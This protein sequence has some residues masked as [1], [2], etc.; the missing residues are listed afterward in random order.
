VVSRPALEAAL[1]SG[2]LAGVGLDVYWEEPWDPADPLYARDD[3]LTLPHVGGS[4]VEVF[5]RIAEL[6]AENV[7]RLAGGEALLHRIA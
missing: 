2:R 6:V 1:A 4:T 3:V 7:R 5:A